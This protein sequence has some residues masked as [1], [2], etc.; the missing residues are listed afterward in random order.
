MSVYLSVAPPDGF[1]RWA[2]ADWDRW[3]REHP[4]EAAERVCSRGD[5][6]IFLYQLRQHAERGKK[7]IEPL[8]EQLVN[9]RPLSTQQA[10]DLKAALAAARDE[11]AK[12]PASLLA[13][14][15]KASPFASRDDV[16]AMIA[17]AR[18]RVGAEPTIADVWSQILDQVERVLENAARERRGV[19]FGNV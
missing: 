8:L 16:L 5:W 14:A 13:E 15:V 7:L 19:Y 10:A 9:E 17:G 2:D 4:W 12:K 6:A 1:S 3:L 18:S 11:L